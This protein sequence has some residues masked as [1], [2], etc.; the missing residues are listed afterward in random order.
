MVGKKIEG[1]KKTPEVYLGPEG[2]I[3]IW[4]RS[5]SEDARGFFEPV[6]A[7]IEEYLKSPAEVTAVEITLEYFNSASAKQIIFILQKLLLLT[8]Q[9]KKLTVNW[10]YEE[11]DDD[12]LEKGEYFSSVLN[13]KF[14]FIELT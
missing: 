1:T 8:L 14:N 7:W 13:M 11:G 5:I 4:G 3:K 12:I 10:F 6:H 9:H 2:V